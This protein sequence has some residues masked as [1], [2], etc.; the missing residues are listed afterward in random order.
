[1]RSLRRFSDAATPVFADLDR[2]TPG[3]SPKR[4]GN[5]T[6]FSAA[7]TVALKSLGNAGEASRADVLRAADPVVKKTRNLARSGVGPTTKLAEFL[8]STAADEG[9]RRVW[10]T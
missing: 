10:P 9:L 7:S 4:P 5:L 3:A 6:P 1:M 2:A 8:V